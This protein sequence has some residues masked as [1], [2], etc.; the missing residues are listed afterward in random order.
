MFM[1]L[2][3][4]DVK[5]KNALASSIGYDAREEKTEATFDQMA[6]TNE[7]NFGSP[8]RYDKLPFSKG[9]SDS[10]EVTKEFNDSVEE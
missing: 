8:E 1:S 9:C 5:K 4:A 7:F 10:I 2:E 3:G 6:E